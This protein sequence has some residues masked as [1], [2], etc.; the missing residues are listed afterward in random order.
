[1]DGISLSKQR[2]KFICPS[3]EGWSAMD[4]WTKKDRDKASTTAEPAGLF[5]IP[6][7]LWWQWSQISA[8]QRQ[9][10]FLPLI[11]YSAFHSQNKMDDKL[12][13]PPAPN[14]AAFL[15]HLFSHLCPLGAE[16]SAVS[17]FSLTGWFVLIFDWHFL[18]TFLFPHGILSTSDAPTTP[19]YILGRRPLGCTGKNH[20]RRSKGERD[21]K[22]M[23]F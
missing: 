19:T 14:L 5:W 3:E 18:K 2:K 23:G 11:I 22:P 13:E 21:I 1:M 16:P 9:S 10:R 6:F 8:Y 12:D 4:T 7:P 17:S 20:S 15:S